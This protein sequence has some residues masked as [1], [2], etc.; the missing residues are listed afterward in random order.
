MPRKTLHLSLQP[1]HLSILDEHAELDTGLEPDLQPQDLIGLHRAMVVTREFDGRMLLLQRQGRLGTFPPTRGQEASQ[2]ASVYPLRASDWMVPSFREVGSMLR[3]G[4]KMEHILLYYAGFEEGAAPPPGV[5]DLPICVPVTSQLPHAVGLAWAAKLKGEEDVVLC[6]LGDGA[7]S[8]G[9]FH[10]ALN[11]ASVYQ[12]P[13]VFL[14][15]NNGWAISLPTSHQT[16]S[17]TLAQKATAFEI[18]ALQVD[19]NDPLAVYSATNEAIER[20]RG[21]GGPTFIEALT[22][23]LSVHTTA[24]DPKRYRTDEEVQRWQRRDPLIRFEKYLDRKGILDASGVAKIRNEVLEEVRSAVENAESM[25]HGSPLDMFDF[26]YQDI[27]PSLL[28]QRRELEEFLRTA[29]VEA[30]VGAASH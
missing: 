5:K 22:Y 1:E 19:G 23:R 20:A 15:Q 6:Y 9:D 26:I 11:F 13:V 29:G 17:R 25:M 4:W 12:V 2:I 18:P 3:R 24:D 10:E 30:A 27:H 14:C 7:T 16:R 8:E 21:G 28:E